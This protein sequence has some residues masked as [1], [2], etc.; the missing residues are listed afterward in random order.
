[1]RI[2]VVGGG[3]IGLSCALRLVRRDHEVTVVTAAPVAD[4]TSM[5]SGG[6]IYPRH[7]EPVDRCARWTAASVREFRRL[8]QVAGAGVRL[9]PGRLLRRERRPVPAWS[10]AVDGFAVDTDPGAPWVDALE[11][12]PPLVNTTLYLPWLERQVRDAG[13]SVEARTVEAL[14]AVGGDVVV[15]AAGLGAGSL[16]GDDTVQPG[17]GQVVHVADPGLTEWVVDEDSFSYVLPHGAHAVCGGTEDLG[18]GSTE[19]SGETT[20]D[21]LRRCAELVPAIADARVLGVR[22][23][24]RPYRPEIRLERVGDVIYCYGHGGVGVTV[25][26]GC[27]DEVVALVDVW[28]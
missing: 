8:A 20:A 10:E 1:M 23:G 21:I 28:G 2:T 12:A 19:P 7:A 11:F 14:S 5:V 15:N 6:L 26:W 25:S 17:R 18:D 22:V 13:V 9:L 16:A 4:T 27:A 24:L 3:I